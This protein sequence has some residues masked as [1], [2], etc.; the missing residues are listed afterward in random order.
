[1]KKPSF[2]FYVGDWKANQ[3]LRRCSWAARGVWIEIMGLMHD[4]EEYGILRWPLE[5]IIHAVGCPSELVH[6]LVKKGVLKGVDKDTLSVTHKESFAQKNKE[7]IEETIID[8]Q[9][10]PFWFSS[11]MVRDEHIRSKRAI[12]GSKSE[13]NPNVPRKK[14]ENDEDKDIDKDTFSPSP[15]SSDSSSL[16]KKESASVNAGEICAEFKQMGM[17]RTNPQHLG[18]VELI[19]QG[20]TREHLIHGMSDAISRGMPFDYG[21]KVAASAFANPDKF[22]PKSQSSGKESKTPSNPRQ[23]QREKYNEGMNNLMNKVK[24]NGSAYNGSQSADPRDI[25]GECEI[26]TD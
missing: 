3:K 17:L 2:Q 5:E 25:T 24:N 16:K 1:M 8:N 4:S 12:H 19:S 7:P 21:I 15:S 9:L 13:N 20:V 26:V 18:L 23:A 6:E 22:K 14:V 10:G 11:R